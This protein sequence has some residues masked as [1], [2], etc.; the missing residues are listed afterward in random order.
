MSEELNCLQCK[1]CAL[2]DETDFS[3]KSTVIWCGQLQNVRMAN[4]GGC[5]SAE[6]TR[7]CAAGRSWSKVA[8]AFLQTHYV[9][10]PMAVLER[11][12]GRNTK[13]VYQRA[14]RLGFGKA[15]C[16]HVMRGRAVQQLGSR[17][18]WTAEQDA[19]LRKIY[20]T[21][22]WPLGGN[23]PDEKPK[24][25]RIIRRVNELGPKHSWRSIKERGRA[26][27]PAGRKRADRKRIRN[28][29]YQREHPK[30]KKSNG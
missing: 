16:R 6:P 17:R 27:T 22:K 28:T 11:A 3:Q 5:P 7:N 15:R 18:S 29:I 21:E 9:T 8:E 25:A 26:T 30:G 14:H 19:Y 24:M 10:A 1:H 4:L 12:L 2:R 23:K 20:G 13:T